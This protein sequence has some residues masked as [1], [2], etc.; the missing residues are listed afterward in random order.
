[1]QIFETGLRLGN[2]TP[3]HSL[4]EQNQKQRK[5]RAFTE[6]P[7]PEGMLEKKS[8]K[9]SSRR[10]RKSF[11]IGK[12]EN[13][14]SG[15]KVNLRARAVKKRSEIIFIQDR[16]QTIKFHS[17]KPVYKSFARR[18]GCAH[19]FGPYTLSS[20]QAAAASSSSRIEPGIGKI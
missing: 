8:K 12:D 14:C 4:R 1:M 11:Q 10:R 5:A 16:Q 7:P 15:T 20:S 13:Y 9:K 6:S 17:F 2:T 3:M 19:T 18:A